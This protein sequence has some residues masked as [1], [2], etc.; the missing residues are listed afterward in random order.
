MAVLLLIW[1][2][3]ALLSAPDLLPG[4]GVTVAAMGK[5]LFQGDM[6]FHV[7]V[8]LARVAAAFLIAM[9]IGT[10]I[11]IALGMSRRI[12][13]FFEFWLLLFLNLP[14]LVTIILCYL[15]FGLTEAAAVAAVAINKI[16][17]VAV[18]L[19]EGSRALDP[20]LMEMARAFRMG[21]VKTLH[22]VI[23]PQLA[24]YLSAA[25]RGGLSLIWKIVLVVEL[26]G[27]GS[28]VGFQLHLFFQLFDVT[29]ILAY[30][31][32]F[33][34]V[35]QMIDHGLFQPVERHINRWR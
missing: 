8:T 20:K 23:L 22:V 17:N 13:R 16:P 34:L 29:N 27:R 31:L 9:A 5:A 35:I 25:A 7:G 14:A 3:A 28:G 4:P 15:W 10:A 30:S 32:A 24:P 1:Q 12:D 18:T 6:L 33:I 19:R 2:G 11:G 26:L 21:P